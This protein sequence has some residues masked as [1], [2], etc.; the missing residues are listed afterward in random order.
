MTVYLNKPESDSSKE[1]D[2]FFEFSNLTS[3]FIKDENVKRIR[4]Q[5]YVLKMISTTNT[6]TFQS[7][8]FT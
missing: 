2:S 6:Y 1:S 8:T 3:G 5:Q 4:R 7:E